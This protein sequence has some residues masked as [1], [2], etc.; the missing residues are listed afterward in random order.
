MSAGGA[1]TKARGRSW[2][3]RALLAAL[4]LAVA[5][6]A[7]APMPAASLT[8]VIKNLRSLSGEVHVAIWNQ[9]DGF[10]D[11]DYSLH[12]VREPVVSTEKQIVFDGLSPGHYALAAY[13]DENGNGKFDRSLIG[14]PAEG[15]GFSNGAWIEAFGPPSFESAAIEVVGEESST[16]I[17]LRY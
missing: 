10:A 16:V 7:A 14:L 15:L 12:Q 4:F 8:V 1:A 9:P 6:P 3:G 17:E 11:G 13:H 2:A 5:A